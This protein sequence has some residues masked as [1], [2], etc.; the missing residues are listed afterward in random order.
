M[1]VLA[2]S[3]IPNPIRSRK[4]VGIDIDEVLSPFCRPMFERAGYKWP[5]GKW[6]YRYATALG[7][8]QKDSERMVYDFYESPEFDELLPLPGAQAGLS[9][10]QAL[11]YDIYIITGR[12]DRVRQKTEK[13]IDHHF[14]YMVNEVIMTNSF[15]PHEV[16]KVD[17]CKSLAIN[18][19]V[20]DSYQ[21]CAE[22]EGAHIKG[23][24]YVGGFE[25]YPWCR[26]T[27]LSVHNW[28]EVTRVVSSLA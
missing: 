7:I 20:D 16:N 21:V 27:T 6:E 13:W 26:K 2:S 9:F 3:G 14:P 12:Q 8:S 4:R 25:P 22:C 5:E 24:N 19:M 17:I 23:I 18:A 10:I 15:T 28:D 11:G 1:N